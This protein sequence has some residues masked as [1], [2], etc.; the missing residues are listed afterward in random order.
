MQ[1]YYCAL[2]DR[3]LITIQS[4]IIAIPVLLNPYRLQTAHPKDHRHPIRP[5]P[6]C[7]TSQLLKS[8]TLAGSNNPLNH[9]MINRATE[10][11]NSSQHNA[12]TSHIQTLCYA[13]NDQTRI[14]IQSRH[15]QLISTTYSLRHS[16]TLSPQA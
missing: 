13:L 3:I 10:P 11:H 8:L 15:H 6:P 12:L 14:A 7:L 16:S 2:R 4:R 1:T 5:S 9:Q